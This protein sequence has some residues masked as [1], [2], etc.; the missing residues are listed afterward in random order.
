MLTL[1]RQTFYW[2]GTDDN[3]FHLLSN[4]LPADIDQHVTQ[5]LL[6]KGA[7]SQHITVNI[8]YPLTIAIRKVGDL[9]YFRST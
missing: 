1:R 5:E 6:V 8:I 4:N 7:L 9:I 2:L 3:F